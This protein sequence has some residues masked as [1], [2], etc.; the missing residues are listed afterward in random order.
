MDV[1]IPLLVRQTRKQCSKCNNNVSFV[2]HKV[3]YKCTDKFSKEYEYHK[4]YLNYKI[5]KQY[6]PN[7]FAHYYE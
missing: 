3:C 2:D 1:R 5:L 7:L 6:Y 4:A